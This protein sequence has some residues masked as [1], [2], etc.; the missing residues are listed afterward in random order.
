MCCVLR[1]CVRTFHPMPHLKKAGLHRG[2][3]RRRDPTKGGKWR[4]LR[5]R[6]SVQQDDRAVLG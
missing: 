4:T 2:K 6:W 1:C 5:I 3:L